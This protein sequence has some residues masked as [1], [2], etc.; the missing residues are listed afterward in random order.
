MTIAAPISPEVSPRALPVRAVYPYVVT[1]AVLASSTLAWLVSRDGFAW[2]GRETVVLVS[3]VAATVLS[4][5]K[6]LRVPR[7]REAEDVTLSTTFAYALALSWGGLAAALA[8]VLGS[9][10][11]GIGTRRPAWKAGFNA[12]QYV[13]SIAGAAATLQFVF[14]LPAGT[15]LSPGDLP[16]VLF[17]GG[18][19]FV[20]NNT[21][22]AT[23][24]GLARGRS[25]V[26]ANVEGLQFQF[27]TTA[28]LVALAP[29]VVILKDWS[30]YAVPLLLLPMAAIYAGGTATIARMRSED[31]FHAM[32]QNAADLVALMDADGT[33]RYVSPSVGL[34]LGFEP[35]ALMGKAA[36]DIVH[37]DDRQKAEAMLSDLVSNVGKVIAPELR[38]VDANGHARH[39]DTVINNLLDNASIRGI[40]LNGRDVTERKVLEHELEHQAF[41]DPLTGLANRALFRDR[42]GHALARSTRDQSVTA[43]LFI[44]LDDFK[45]IN[46]SLGHAAGDEVLMQVAGRVRGC[47]R[48]EDTAS[49]LGGDEFAILIEV[50]GRSTAVHVAQR[51]LDGLSLP[52]FAQ[53]HEV[54]VRASVG[55]A[56]AAAGEFS[57]EELLRNA[58][59]AMY[60]AKGHGKERY[61][62]YLPDMRTAAVERVELESDLRRAIEG[63]ELFL[64][65]Q[66]VV[67]LQDG[68]IIGVEA[69]VRWEHPRRGLVSPASFIP[70]AEEA[71]LIGALGRFVLTAATR[72]AQRWASEG[73][74]VRVN[75]NVSARQL[76]NPGFVNEVAAALEESGLDPALLVMEITETTV[77]RD[78]DESL[79]RLGQLRKLGVSLAIDDF[80]TGYSSLSYLKRFPIDVLKIDKSF[81]DGLNGGVEES[82][83]VRAIVQIGRTL[84]LRTVAEGIEH[85]DQLA[86]LRR[87]GC[88]AGQGFYFSP[89]LGA[90]EISA[91]LAGPRKISHAQEPTRVGARSL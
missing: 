90:R 56:F 26:E 77:M 89:P 44:D 37:P 39:F 16:P 63:E 72:Q 75:V 11:A 62:V 61:E 78:A 6:P 74:P 53:Q 64:H 20:I 34:I 50:A 4:E 81:I 28:A 27:A 29:V 86:E 24:I 69:L 45:T 59:V 32:A 80:G 68:R 60:A 17:A 51:F 12:S 23:A 40:V 73:S 66:P 31:R 42:V 41:H 67:A 14:D 35:Q 46:D 30:I 58:D 3:L 48:P 83:L 85:A 49:R 55:I 10:V 70:L 84:K 57:A 9:L 91:L 79:L 25:I 54:V 15:P 82:A 36:F 33:L 88:D 43:V 19:F 1:V 71:G 5:M 47:L 52:F 38:L 7:G 76:Q 2:I 18:V 22:V 13:L 8:L 87:I 21:L 65:Y